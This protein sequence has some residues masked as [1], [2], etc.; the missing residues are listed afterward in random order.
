LCVERKLAIKIGEFER[1][2]LEN[3]RKITSNTE[4]NT[5]TTTLK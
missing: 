3:L 5:T 1:E 4:K 2:K